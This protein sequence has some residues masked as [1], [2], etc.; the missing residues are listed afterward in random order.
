[1][2][3]NLALL[4]AFAVFAGVSLIIALALGMP[5]YAHLRAIRRRE[6][7]IKTLSAL[8]QVK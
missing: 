1:M 4:V 2:T 5:A 8:D 7:L 3:S 6:E